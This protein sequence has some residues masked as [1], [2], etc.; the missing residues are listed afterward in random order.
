MGEQLSFPDRE[1]HMSWLINYFTDDS[2]NPTPAAAPNALTPE[3]IRSRRLQRFQ[4]EPGAAAS[5]DADSSTADAAIA[6]MSLDAGPAQAGNEAAKK[7]EGIAE[8]IC[9][10]ACVRE[11]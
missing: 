3:Q 5:S 1:E 4:N 6:S 2:S 10:L 9:F 11:E 8:D 7:L